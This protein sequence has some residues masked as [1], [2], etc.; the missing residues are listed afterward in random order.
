MSA[1]ALTAIILVVGAIV[2]SVGYVL[3]RP[4]GHAPPPP[5]TSQRDRPPGYRHGNFAES[6]RDPEKPEHD[7]PGRLL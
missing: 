1:D 7:E 2:L 6:M 3:A 5:D 4:R